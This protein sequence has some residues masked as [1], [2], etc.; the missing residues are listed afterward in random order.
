MQTLIVASLVVA[1][2]AVPQNYQTSQFSA[3][4]RSQIDLLRRESDQDPYRGIYRHIYEQNNGQI[5]AEDIETYPGPEPETGSII[6]RGSFQ[7]VGDDGNTYQISYVANEGGFQP[8]GAHL[9]VAP[10]QI[11][12]YAQLRQEHPEL[13]WAEGQQ[14]QQ[15]TYV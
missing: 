9:P 5:V 3:I 4:P 8:R 15:P 10:A 7:F 11:P 6:Q 12:E 1:A 13:F 2:T 14:P